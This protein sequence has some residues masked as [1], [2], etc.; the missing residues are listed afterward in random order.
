MNSNKKRVLALSAVAIL[1]A[2]AILSGSLAYF[3]DT[4]KAKNTF[5]VGKDVSVTQEE[6]ERDDNGNLVDFTQNKTLIPVTDNVPDKSNSDDLVSDVKNYVDKIVYVRNNSETKT[7]VRTFIAVPKEL[8][9]D[10]NYKLLHFDSNVSKW[11][12]NGYVTYDTTINGVVY[13]VYVATYAD[14]VS[15]DMRTDYV[16]KGVYLDKAVDVNEDGNLIYADLSNPGASAL[17]T[18]GFKATDKINV[19]VASQ[20]V[21]SEGFDNA[22]QALNSAFGVP[23]SANL[24]AFE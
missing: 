7:Y 12:F 8:V 3:T 21:Q 4:D 20:A 1:A 16:L 18:T 9:S 11:N 23:S 17:V 22:T 2:I 5:V 19:Y 24:P 10:A 13:S 15:K 6:K 14:A